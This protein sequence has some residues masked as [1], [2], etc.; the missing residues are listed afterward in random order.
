MTDNTAGTYVVTTLLGQICELVDKHS[1][2]INDMKDGFRDLV[3][4]DPMNEIVMS[5]VQQ[6]LR[7]ALTEEGDA[8][9][10]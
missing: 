5:M 1:L 2:T 7:M 8:E 4:H 6:A 10:G 3:K 9:E